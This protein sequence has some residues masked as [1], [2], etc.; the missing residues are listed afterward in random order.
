VM[1]RIFAVRKY[2][3]TSA[4]DRAEKRSITADIRRLQGLGNS[5]TG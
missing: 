2:P 1:S 3:F 4:A 5:G